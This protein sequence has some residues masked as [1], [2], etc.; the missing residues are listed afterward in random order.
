MEAEARS[1][2][3]A[4]RAAADAMAARY[5]PLLTAVVDEPHL[6]DDE[7]RQRLSDLRERAQA[8]LEGV[9]LGYERE[10]GRRSGPGLP[11]AADAEGRAL[12]QVMEAHRGF[13]ALLSQLPTDGD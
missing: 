1:P 13:L 9:R 7:K 5:Q 2:F 4:A 11:E 6:G 12:G 8:E 3:E 10:R